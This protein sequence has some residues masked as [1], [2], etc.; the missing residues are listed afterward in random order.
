MTVLH[1]AAGC[2]REGGGL[3]EV[4][5]QLVR[6]Q[7]QAGH[8]VRLVFM[9]ARPEHPLLARCRE[10]GAEVRAVHAPLDNPFF[11]S[12]ALAKALPGWMRGCDCVH[13]HGCWTWPVWEA[14]RCARRAGIP[15]IHS[16]HGS[17]DPVRRR[18]GRMRKGVAWRLF[19]RRTLSGAA[20]L[21]ATSE[22]E[23]EWI[24]NALGA[25]TPPVRIIPLGVDGELL[26]S[27]P[28]Q[29]R[30]KS[31]L[32]LGRLH[33]LK[34]LD[35]LL[36]AWRRAALA[37]EWR[38]TLA[39]PREGA[40]FGLAPG[41]EV[42]PPCTGAEKV[43]LL[44]SAACLVLPTRS[45]NFGL[46]VAEALWCRTPVVCTKGAPWPELGRFWV[47]PAPD[48]LATAL[49]QMAAMA[50]GDR[51]TAFRSA[52]DSAR[53]RFDWGRLAGAFLE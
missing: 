16:P 8:R 32:F 11:F 51:E 36:E 22:R 34:G 19:D 41:V 38:L 37:P 39:G 14:A 44:K 25:A 45:E 28:P 42:L 7:A 43:R 17:L 4:V 52:F 27:V 33:P 10:L 12:P 5:A 13:L 29:P 47:E 53:R 6:A 48:A 46:V 15:Y 1:L 3:S 50:V 20:W 23:A 9:D 24:R 21:H 40:R 35:L 18:F 30:T 31:F 2:W 49:R 26:D